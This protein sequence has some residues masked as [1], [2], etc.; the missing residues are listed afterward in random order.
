MLTLDFTCTLPNGI[1]ARPASEIEQRAQ[2][3][4]ASITLIN[5]S[6]K[7]QADAKSVLGMIGADI[8]HGDLCQFLIEGRDQQAAFDLLHAFLRDEFEDC[9]EPLAVSPDNHTL[10]LPVF[11]EHANP[12]YVRGN[13]VSKGIGR[14][15]P[16]HIDAVDLLE[17]SRLEPATD[18]VRQQQQLKDAW[19]LTQ[20]NFGDADTGAAPVLAAQLKLLSDPAFKRCLLSHTTTRNALQAI[21]L[22][23]QALS[24]PLLKSSSQYLRERVIDIRDLCQSIA[25]NLLGRALEPPLT[26]NQ[27]SIVISSGTL[28]PGQF[29]RLRNPHLKGIVMGDGGETSHTVILARSFGIPLLSGVTQCDSIMRTASM[30][31]LDSRHGVLVANPN[32]AMESWYRM[33]SEKQQRISARSAPLRGQQVLTADGTPVS[34][35]ANIALA[36][37]AQGVFAQGADGIGLFRTEMLFCE[38]SQAPDEEEQYQAY[39]EVLRCAAG[40]KITIRTL[41]IGGD[42]PCDFLDLPKEENPFLGY[43]AVR[44]YPQFHDIFTTQARA[45]L[46]ASVAGPLNIMVPMVATLAEIQWLHSQFHQ[47]ADTLQQGE[48]P[49]GEWHLGIMVEVPS[50]LYLLEKAAKYLDFVSIGSNDLAQYFFAC[51]RG[52]PYVRHLYDYRNPTFLALMRDITQR[53]QA[54]G[55]AISLCGE[56]AADKQMLPLL[57]GMGLTQ[58]SMA[59][60]TIASCKE[61]LMS[62]NIQQCQQLLETAILSESS[63]DVSEHVEQFMRVQMQKPVL[64]ADLLLLDKTVSSKEEAI[65]LLTDNLEVQQRVVSGSLVEKAIWE[66]EAVFSTALGFSVAIPHCKS[67]HILHSSI[68]LL[69]LTTPLCWGEDVD[70]QLVIMLTVNEQEQEDHM[71]IFSRL[72]RKLMHSD[73]REKLYMLSD[74]AAITAL[75]S[76]ELAL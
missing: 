15:I 39:S 40:K 53:A 61:A 16:V 6:K 48:I 52:N 54:A 64:D 17:L 55:L 60:G 47:I 9:D 56:M 45:L 44:M 35:L 75:L 34:V 41:D 66:R 27:D 71:K 70:V 57:V 76:T 37:E 36:V 62:L 1:H 32:A 22:T 13:G 20:K 12:D 28:T 68:S 72:A 31:I 73:F 25:A 58:L 29:L 59:A 49:V 43:R 10:P 50:T 42:K 67:P 23:A 74:S 33:E 51:D 19:A 38:R 69:R 7:T 5:L 4:S 21:A 63:E 24:E 30:L 8:T 11:I 26:L 46:R 65:K 2:A 3:F 18:A 14:G